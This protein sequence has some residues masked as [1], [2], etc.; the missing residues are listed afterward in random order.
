MYE[1]ILNST[2]LTITLISAGHFFSKI[3]LQNKIQ[4][5]I[6]YYGILGIV[7]LSILSFILNL[8]APLNEMISN[9]IFIFI[10]LNFFIIKFKNKLQI[11]NFIKKIIVLILLNILLIS[12]SNYYD[13]DGA[14]Y[15]LPFSRL[16][17]DYKIILG[18]ASLHPMF[19]SHSI[20]QYFA[21]SLHN[22]LTGPD[23]VLFVNSL[24]GAFF[25]MFFYENI[26]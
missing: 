26:N 16:I 4:L 3:I 22:S 11:T 20:L 2:I 9:F 13:P 1:I 10:I 5:E 8:L 18:S 21:A 17:N 23:G 15:H 14:W 24:I 12:Y 25:L 7:F 6:T 19:G